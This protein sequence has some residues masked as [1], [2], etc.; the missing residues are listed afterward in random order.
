MTPPR[1][2]RPKRIDRAAEARTDLLLFV[3]GS[4]TEQDYFTYLHRRY[5]RHVSLAIDDFRGGPLQLVER[6]VERQK[7]EARNERKGRGR[8]HDAVWCVF[9]IDEHPNVEAAVDLAA[10]NGVN[11]A[12]SNPCIELWFL[13]HFVDQTAFIERDRA[14]RASETHLGCG[15]ALHDGACTALHE[16]F[17]AAS[18]RAQRLIQKH[19]MDGSPP[20]SNP[21]SGLWEL[22]Q[23]IRAA[24]VP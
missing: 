19:Q 15:K 16:R 11:L 4:R 20:G 18:R 3:E 9:D 7:D 21:S 6:A 5:R 12:I 10:A 14:Q 13:L 23:I 17:D 1:G 24:A 22:V 2:G 8:A